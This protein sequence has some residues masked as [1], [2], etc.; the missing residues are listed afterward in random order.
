MSIT[1]LAADRQRSIPVTVSSTSRPLIALATSER[2]RLLVLAVRG[3]C[4]TDGRLDVFEMTGRERDQRCTAAIAVVQSVA[5]AFCASTRVIRPEQMAVCSWFS[6]ESLGLVNQVAV[7][8]L[9]SGH[10]LE[11]AL[12]PPS[13][14]LM[15]WSYSVVLEG[16]SPY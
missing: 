16:V 10:K 5:M 8:A 11:V 2:R 6:T 4:M 3:A 7:L 12:V 14:R 15:R 13:S 1:R 9:G